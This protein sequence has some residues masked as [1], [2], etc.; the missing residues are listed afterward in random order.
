M[1]ASSLDSNQ[2]AATLPFALNNNFLTVNAVNTINNKS[3][4]VELEGEDGRDLIINTGNHVTINGGTGNDTITGSNIYDDLFMFAYNHGND[5]ITNFGNRDTLQIT[6]GTLSTTKSNNDIIVSVKKSNTTGKVT[7]K[8]AANIDIKKSGNALIA[9]VINYIDNTKNKKKVNGTDGRDF[10]TSTGSNVTVVP[11]KGDDTV[12]G[13]DYYGDWFIFSYAD[14]NNL[15]TN[16]SANDSLKASDDGT[17]TTQPS[18]D[19]AIVTITKSKMSSKITLEGAANLPFIIKNNILTVKGVP[20]LESSADDTKLTGT[21]VDE[22]LIGRHENISIQAGKGNDT[23]EGSEYGETFIFSYA[24]NDDVILNFG[25]NDTLKSTS[26]NI[27]SVEKKDNDLL[28]TITKGSTSGTILLKNAATLKY[29]F[30]TSALWIDRIN[31]IE[32]T[33]NNQKVSGTTDIDYITNSEYENVTIQAGK[34]ND[35]IEGSDEYGEQFWFSYASDDDVILNF[36]VNDTLKITSGTMSTAKSGNDFIVTAT[37][38]NTVGK[39]TLQ[40]VADYNFKKSDAYLIVDNVNRIVNTRN[41]TLV[42]GT[43][44]NDFISNTDYSN[45]TIDGAGGNDTLDG[46]D[47]FGDVFVFNALGGE[48]I[49]TN[50]NANDTLKITEGSISS[51]TKVGNDYVVNVR[52]SNYIGTITLKGSGALDFKQRDSTL[53]VGGVNPMVN[54]SNKKKIVG[55]DFD[56]RITNSGSKVTINGAGGNDTI[57]GSSYGEIFQFSSDG[58]NDVILN[59]GKNDSLQIVGGSIKSREQNGDD[60]VV[61]VKSQ[62]Y[63]GTITLKNA[64]HY[65]FNEA[66]NVLTVANVNY[67]S[68]STDGIKVTGTGK[69][70]FITNSG[71]NVTLGGGAGNDTFEGSTFGETYL[72]AYTGGSDV[73][74]NFGLNDTLQITSGTLSTTKSGD[75]LLV[76]ATKSGKSSTMTLKGAGNYNFKKSGSALFVD[77]INEIINDVDKKKITGTGGRDYIANTGENVTIQAGKGDDVITGSDLFGERF[78]FSY[79]S[80]N[81][82]ITNFS[83][84]DTIQSTSGTLSYKQSGNDVIVTIKKGSTS[85]TVVLQDAAGYVFKQTNTYLTVETV[86]EIDNGD[87]NIKVT[88]TTGRDYIVNT[89]ENVS[90]QSGK[91][92]DT[93]DGSI[94]GETFMFSYL[95]G[96]NLITNFGSNDTIRNTSGTMSCKVN[97]DDVIVSITKSKT[98]ATITLEGAAVYSDLIKKTNAALYVDGINVIENTE[99]SQKITGTTGRDC[100]VNTGE[101]VTIQAGKGNDLITGSDSFGERFLFSYASG[102]DTITNFGLGDTIQS[103]SG[104]PSFKQSGNDYIVSIKKSGQKSVGTITLTDAAE[105]YSLIKSGSN[106]IASPKMTSSANAPEEYWFMSEQSIDDVSPLDQIVENETVIDLPA[107]FMSEVLKRKSNDVITS[108][109]R[110]D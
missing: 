107:D 24:S 56:D 49:I 81:D 86:N 69:A 54:S 22:Y 65:L 110:V 97:G 28:V 1:R 68:N 50:F 34:G 17:I 96:N 93:I 18:G 2:G 19:D 109:R 104:T 13:S 80:G 35:T 106:L 9:D 14:G 12:E 30:N 16:F 31:Y 66:G 89:G 51:R 41:K 58:G 11:G 73:I 40:G 84:G 92:N 87:D 83:L 100:I 32:A 95:A 46:S 78:L 98:T 42:G 101:K 27:T 62:I 53:I 64:G 20:T 38:N 70:D 52:D 108:T 37:K 67:M 99:D 90:I 82:T 39:I 85:G 77:N 72:F 29:K 47:S 91:G 36:G 43:D 7:L 23:I 74:T 21:S 26:G 105:N 88:G 75:D 10:I 3:D 79:A 63:T 76:K 15:I 94:F 55:T 8:G 60:Y 33:K 48:D 59:F 57:E 25:E 5:V 71:Q 61:T 102:D 6:A 45:V 103:T 4:D 44:G